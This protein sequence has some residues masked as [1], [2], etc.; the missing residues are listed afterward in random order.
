M[1][2]I[3]VKP[4]R[5]YKD[6]RI[7]VSKIFKDGDWVVVG[8]DKDGY[9]KMEK[10]EV[11]LENIICISRVRDGILNLGKKGKEEISDILN[12]DDDRLV[13][14]V[15]FKDYAIIGKGDRYVL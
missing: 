8:R 15:K 12:L 5:L 10:V 3:Y 9:I 2:N 7:N 13:V 1:H 14:I 6:G 11:D 4:T